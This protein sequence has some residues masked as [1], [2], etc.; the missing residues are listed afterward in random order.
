[1][2]T[3]NSQRCDYIEVLNSYL[4]EANSEETEYDVDAIRVRL[5][6]CQQLT[7]EQFMLN[8]DYLLNT[9][10]A[11]LCK[12][13]MGVL[14]PNLPGTAVNP[15]ITTYGCGVDI[16]GDFNIH[17]DLVIG[18]DKAFEA[19]NHISAR[20][21]ALDLL[22]NSDAQFTGY[23]LYPSD[24]APR[25][26]M[27][28]GNRM[29]GE[30][31][32]RDP[33]DIFHKGFDV[34]ELNLGGDLVNLFTH[35]P[36]PFPKTDIVGMI[37][38]KHPELAQTRMHLDMEMP[39]SDGT[40]NVMD[41]VVARHY[42][43]EFSQAIEEAVA[44]PGLDKEIKTGLSLVSEVINKHFSGLAM[45]KEIP[46]EP[47]SMVQMCSLKHHPSVVNEQYRSKAFLNVMPA[48]HAEKLMKNMQVMLN[49][50]SEQDDPEYYE[51]VKTEIK[52]LRYIAEG[53]IKSH[54]DVNS[55]WVD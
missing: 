31:E 53:A 50:M 7:G 12:G 18:V 10:P 44:L 52:R 9:H 36:N 38:R 51:S 35:V 2:N 49:L 43:S 1:M 25:M 19:N 26:S 8:K 45:D 40:K 42:M 55:K 48:E 32:R 47:I 20:I 41:A 39:I 3:F 5:N 54:R 16:D 21:Q 46:N 34:S 13:L 14:L 22:F 37:A 11:L 30:S 6:F 24:C 23:P 4:I 15:R 33:R 17:G 29:T 28:G 27:Y